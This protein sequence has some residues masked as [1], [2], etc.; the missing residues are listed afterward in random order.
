[1][2]SVIY[3]GNVKHKRKVPLEHSFRYPIYFYGFYL[4]ELET[5]DKEVKGFSYNHWNFVSIYDKDYLTPDSLPIRSKLLILLKT[6]AI[7][8]DIETVFLV[9]SARYINYVFNPVSFYFCFNNQKK[10]V[11][12]VVEVNNTFHERH[13]YILHE[14]LNDLTVSARQFIHEKQFHVSPFNDMEGEYEFT[15][16]E[17]SKDLELEIKIDLIKRKTIILSTKLTGKP[18]SLNSNNLRNILIRYPLLASLTIPRIFLQ[19][20]KLYYV[21]KL[22]LYSKPT[23]LHTNTIIKQKPTFIHR[24]GMA[25]V[26]RI[27]SRLQSGQLDVIF[28]DGTFWTFGQRNTA[29][30]TIDVRDYN[31]FKEILCRGEI[32]LGKSYMDG[33][34]D[35]R[36]LVELMRLFINNASIMNRETG[37]FWSVLFGMYNRIS[38]YLKN[39]S[40]KG[41]LKNI[42]DHYDLGNEFFQK[43]LDETMLYSCGHFNTTQDSLHQAQLNK[44]KLIS[45]KGRIEDSHHV[46]EIGSGWGGFAI[47]LART[48]GC[49][50]TTVTISKNQYEHVIHLVKK[51]KLDDRITVLFQDYREVQGTFDRIVSIEMLEAVGHKYYSVFFQ[52]C[53]QLLG[54]QGLIVLQVITIPDHRYSEYRRTPDWIQR[55]IFPGGLLPSVTELSKA[56]TSNSRL[57]IE[58]LENFGPHYA[59]TLHHWR[60][61]LETHW[62]ELKLMGYSDTL[63]RKWHYYFCYCEAGFANRIINNLQIVLTRQQNSVLNDDQGR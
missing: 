28:P 7:D 55:Y 32:G 52:K 22:R 49:R 9:T 58:S 48:A 33:D 45:S 24:A 57:F 1:M 36:D 30:Q 16:S 59:V 37:S 4:E 44:M 31:F 23:P 15:F 42:K 51:A 5:L 26:Q 47:Y 25:I 17:I 39:N 13:I 20:F 27:L 40:I 21:K 41:S 2:E 14:H 8:E 62:N 63:L 34:W 38:Y 19:A 6:N 35:T 50:V 53:E 61:N 56:M 60:R 29:K 12:I 10:C 3:I 11:C 18:I 54:T 43:I 46:L